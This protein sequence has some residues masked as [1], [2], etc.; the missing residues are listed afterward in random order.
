MFNEVRSDLA[1]YCV[2]ESTIEPTQTL[3]VRTGKIEQRVNSRNADRVNFHCV[4]A[5]GRF[6][7]LAQSD[8]SLLSVRPEPPSPPS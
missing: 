1:Q 7:Q 6:R 4:C 3:V 2:K 5:N 8:S